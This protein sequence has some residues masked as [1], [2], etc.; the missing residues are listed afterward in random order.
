MVALGGRLYGLDPTLADPVTT[1]QRLEV[2]DD[3]T[4]R[5]ADAPGYGAPGEQL[6]YDRPRRLDP[7]RPWWRWLLLLPFEAY[8]RQFAS[9]TRVHLGGI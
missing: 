9:R 4:L 5:I 3:D 7:L 1:P 2:V 6:R 8:T